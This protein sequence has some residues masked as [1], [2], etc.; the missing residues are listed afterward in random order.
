MKLKLILILA[1]SISVTSVI[2]Q[3]QLALL[4]GIDKY[5][6]PE[7]YQPS[8]KVGRLEFPDLE[9]CRNDALAV[10][11]LIV[12]KFNF[13][14]KNIDTLFNE[15][16]TREGILNGLNSM[17][18]KSKS[19]DIVFLYYAGH[20]SQVRNSL[21]F[22]ADKKDQTIVPSDTWKEG[23]RDIRDKELSKIFNAF[24][25]KN[26]KLTVIFDCCH[27]GSLSRGPNDHVS[28][29]RYMPASNWDS[30]D[31]S[32]P[33]IPETR[34]EKSFLIFSAAQSDEFASEQ[35]DEFG[36]PHGAF[37]IA[38]LES[39]K[40][41]SVDASAISVF[42]SARAILKSNGKKQEPVLGGNYGRQQETLFGHKKGTL[43][44]YS[45]V[46]VTAVKEASVQLQGG[47]A[48]G[49]M[50][51][52][53]LAYLDDKKDTLFKL[54]IDTVLGINKSMASVIKGN[55]KDIKPG[56]Q[57]RVTNWVSSGRPLLK[58]YIPKSNLTESEVTKFVTIAKELK[59]S[60]KI[61]WLNSI[62]KWKASPYATVFWKND[63]CYVKVDTARAKEISNITAASFLQY[64]KKDSTLYVEMP[65]AK[66]NADEYAAVLADNRSIK[67]INDV[68]AA[69]YTLFGILGNNGLPAYGLRKAEVSVK[70]SLESMP[71]QTD[72]FELL[73]TKDNA[74]KNIGDSLAMMAL[75]LSKLR[76]W[77]NLEVPDAT[78]KGFSYHLEIINEANKQP[79][80]DSKYKVGSAVSLKLVANTDFNTYPSVPKY[81]YVFAVDQAGNMA[82]FY[83]QDDGNVSNKFPKYD[84][85]ALVKE[86]AITD[87]WLI[88]EP[89]G[90]DNYF[91][92]AS[93]EPIANAVVVFTQEGVYSG[94]IRSRGFSDS[95]PLSDL[96]DMGNRGSRGFL[97]KMA[98]T[99]SLQKLSF[100]CTF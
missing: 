7:N 85:G 49:L 73:A 39:L 22:E 100:R 55:I 34:S 69:H 99:W 82:L 35:T 98:S 23:V 89:S 6:P 65:I 3:Q 21:S 41:Q 54:R 1:L 16:A 77:L 4:I 29:F 88:P 79:I 11:S 83:P 60:A 42:A 95:N 9:G 33:A 93:D 80:T 50:K 52:N 2:A 53:E 70:D 87:T 12:S 38:F 36:N 56:V 68:S 74:I 72:C 58:L 25:D 71:I 78:K 24:L 91:L 67:V 18:E 13:V 92:L 37:T 96:L 43:A 63:K 46:A 20:G 84:N 40:Q 17:L 48:L 8:S 66:T 27:S 47:F 10:Q 94:G 81:I 76:G 59:A 14:N 44:D 45:F 32:K 62:G 5:A 90:T 57:F 19:G 51:E 28:K 15:S 26:V 30:K 75:K 31:D 86:V 97:Q 64:C 61:K